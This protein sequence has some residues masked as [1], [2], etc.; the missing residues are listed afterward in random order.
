MQNLF[1]KKPEKEGPEMAKES[2]GFPVGGIHGKHDAG[3]LKSSLAALPGVT[4]VS[5]LLSLPAVIVDYDSTGMEK[6]RLRDAIAD[7]G[8]RI[9]ETRSQSYR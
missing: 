1:W 8:Y 6:A 3:R 7:L 9:P 2:V 5:E 4:S